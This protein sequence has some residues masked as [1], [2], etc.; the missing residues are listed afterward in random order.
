MRSKEALF[1]SRQLPRKQLSR[2]DAIIVLS[3]EGRDPTRSLEH[4]N[5]RNTYIYLIELKFC[6]ET[7]PEQTLRTAQNQHQNTVEDLRTKPLGAYVAITESHYILSLLELPELLRCKPGRMADNP[8][9]P[10]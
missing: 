1:P 2:P 3:L 4:M 7:K 6:S 9:D 10:H 8:P 5:P